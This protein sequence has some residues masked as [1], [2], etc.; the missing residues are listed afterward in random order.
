VII[1]KEQDLANEEYVKKA[2]NLF[3]GRE[4]DKE[5]LIGY[6]EQLNRCY[7]TRQQ[8]II[9]LVESEEYNAKSRNIQSVK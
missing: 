2:F 5:A 9:L 1:T 6:V 8:L 4:P 3:L 7:L